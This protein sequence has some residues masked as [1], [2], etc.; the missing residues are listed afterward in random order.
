MSKIAIDT[1]TDCAFL[2]LEAD[3]VFYDAVENDRNHSE[4]LLCNIKSLLS[5]DSGALEKLYITQGPGSFTG[6]RV[7]MSCIKGISCALDLPVYSL[8]T[9]QTYAYSFTDS[10]LCDNKCTV[11]PL[12][13]AKKSRFYSS[14]F[15]FD[16]SILK[17]LCDDSD[18]SLDDISK[19]IKSL[20][21][22]NIVFVCANGVDL[23]G[24]DMGFSYRQ[25]SL[26]NCINPAH[27]LILH[28][29][30]LLEITQGPV[31]VRPVDAKEYLHNSP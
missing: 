24:I 22:D 26:N 21:V 4:N 3:G 1:S 14:V 12:I 16:G 11:V 29:K 20:R 10:L 8:S 18:L 27:S 13:D 17:R 5:K 23:K 6:L 19:L 28:A 9:L 2:S 30:N 7:G 31:Y 25:I 15:S